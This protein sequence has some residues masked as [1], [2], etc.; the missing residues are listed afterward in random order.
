MD[1]HDVVSKF[2]CTFVGNLFGHERGNKNNRRGPVLHQRQAIFSLV[3][4]LGFP[5]FSLK[6]FFVFKQT[7][8]HCASIL[9]VWF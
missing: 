7:Y 3:F 1:E 8:H 5:C 4:D 6:P 2:C 9:L